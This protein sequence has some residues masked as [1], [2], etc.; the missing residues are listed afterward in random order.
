MA[1]QNPFWANKASIKSSDRLQISIRN[2]IICREG[3]KMILRTW[4]LQIKNNSPGNYLVSL[5]VG[6]VRSSYCIKVQSSRC[7][8]LS[9]S[10][11]ICY[12][13]WPMGCVLLSPPVSVDGPVK[14][15]RVRPSVKTTPLQ[16]IFLCFSLICHG[17]VA[18]L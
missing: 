17:R 11:V 6:S 7:V 9:C 18:N 12:S 16:I 13:C 15:P 8:R 14:V 1:S 4:D 3:G 10:K 5:L 2:N